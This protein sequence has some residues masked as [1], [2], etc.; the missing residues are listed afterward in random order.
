MN[1]RLLGTHV[2]ISH[3]TSTVIFVLK[4]PW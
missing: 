1:N 4:L 3:F 2:I